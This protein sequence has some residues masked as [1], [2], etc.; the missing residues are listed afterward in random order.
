ML[1]SC[2]AVG[3]FLKGLFASLHF[4]MIDIFRAEQVRRNKE[5]N[6]LGFINQF[7]FFLFPIVSNSPRPI[8]AFFREK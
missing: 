8:K 7:I 3:G 5:N 4:L 6:Y 1:L 2:L